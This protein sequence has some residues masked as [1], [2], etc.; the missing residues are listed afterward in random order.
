MTTAA[1]GESANRR[2][3]QLYEISKLFISFD[4]VEN[5]VDAALKLIANKLPLESAILIEATIG[6]H[7]DM[8]VW[9]C[10]D[11]DPERLERAKAHATEAYAYLVGAPSVG[12]LDV[13]EPVRE[14]LGPTLLPAPSRDGEPPDDARRFIV[15]PLVVGGGMVFG[16]LQLESTSQ[17]DRADLEFINAIA[18]QLAITLDRNRARSYDVLRRRE[19]ERLQAKY[20]ALVDHLDYAFAWEANAETRRITYVS[21]QFER[22]LGFR[23]QL[24]LDEP[25][26]WSAHV[27]PDDREQLQH[28]FERALVEPGN[29]RCEHRCVTADG[30]IR[31]LRTS[32]HLVGAGDEPPLLQGVSFDVTAAR[33]VEDQV[34]EQLSFLTTMASTLAEGALAVDL[35]HRITFLND[36]GAA[37]LGCSRR[38]TL[39]KPSAS[40][41]RIET[42]DGAVVESPLAAALRTGRVHSGDHVIVRADRGRF[43][44]SYTATAIRRDGTVTGAV[45]TFE[46]ISDRKQARNAEPLP[47]S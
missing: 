3:E 37:L 7:T 12:A 23:R 27:H 31:W 4:I 22:M 41:A 47:H 15:I 42:P 2:L 44:A 13:H 6:G 5:T 21:A 24:C 18:N 20:E 9:P 36:A 33:A 8:V 32:I 26:W 19:A 40:V 43:P 38:E 10:E 46:D 39:G 25:D 30:S 29:K 16:A 45:L 28:T 1:A 35:E 14:E 17:L 34:R 11:N